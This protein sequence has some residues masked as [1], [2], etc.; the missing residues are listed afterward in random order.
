MVPPQ[1]LERVESEVAAHVRQ[2]K[3][4]ETVSMINPLTPVDSVSAFAMARRL[5]AG[6]LFDVCV[7]VAPEGNVYGYFFARFGAAILS[8]HVDYPPR[9]CEILDDLSP[10]G[11]KQ[12]LILED[13]VASGMSLRHVV[14]TLLAYQ[15]T[16]IDLYLGRP[17]DCQT[18]EY[19][20]PAIR[21]VYLAE[22]YLDASHRPEYE[23][24][25]IRFF[26]AGS[27]CD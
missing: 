15:P 21:T 18:L 22:D 10:L 19:I 13:D 27:S 23:E 4:Y 14:R 16:A 3:G 6:N 9:R 17:K 7:A 8:V 25:F 20:D 11:G 26:S 1:L 12:V 2:S 24:E 5:T